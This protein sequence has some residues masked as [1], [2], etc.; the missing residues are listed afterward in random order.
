MGVSMSYDLLNRNP[1]ERHINPYWA[2]IDG[3]T[4]INKNSKTRVGGA[5]ILISNALVFNKI[6]SLRLSVEGC[7]DIWAE[8]EL[9]YQKSLIVGSIYRHPRAQ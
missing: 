3:Y 4:L 1:T 9:P 8:I 6:D 7:E 5:A 2:N